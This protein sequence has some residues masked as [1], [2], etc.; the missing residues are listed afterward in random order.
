LISGVMPLASAISSSA[1]ASTS[2]RVSA[3]LP[4]RVAYKSAVFAPAIGWRAVRLALDRPGLFRLQVRAL[5]RAASGR[6]LRLMVPMVSTVSEIDAARVLID[7]EIALISKRGL[8]GPAEVQ[9]GVMVEV[10]SILFDLDAVLPK[11][12]FVSIGSNDLLQFLFAA[13]RSNPLVA[14]RYDPL[15]RPALRVLREVQNAGD[16]HGVPVTLCGEMAAHPLEAMALIGLGY[17]SISMAP[18][19][20]GPVKK[21]VLSLDAGR[22]AAFLDARLE[23]CGPELLRDELRQFAESEGIEF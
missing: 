3:K 17:R 10:P 1:P 23:D 4:C 12:D 15:S 19:A 9:V 14:G 21:M 5:L 16:R 20:I 11:V 22:L 18:A 8:V 7:R 13:D 6:S 2:K